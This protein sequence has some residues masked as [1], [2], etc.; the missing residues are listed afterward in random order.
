M[1]TLSLTR[2]CCPHRSKTNYHIFIIRAFIAE[3][4]KSQELI[5]CVHWDEDDVWIYPGDFAHG[6]NKCGSNRESDSGEK[7]LVCSIT[8][9][10]IHMIV[11]LDTRRKTGC[12]RKSKNKN[13]N[14]LLTQHDT[15]SPCRHRQRVLKWL[16]D[17]V[18]SINRDGA[19]MQDW[20]CEQ[21]EKRIG[22]I[23]IILIMPSVRGENMMGKYF[24]HLPYIFLKYITK[25]CRLLLS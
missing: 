24:R 1:F 2:L 12:G 19:Q 4:V 10:G 17:R 18:V 11:I 15:N 21:R 3:N 6:E 7:A 13:E 16:A 8:R 25:A 14:L 22:N 23:T 5:V 20:H 9:E